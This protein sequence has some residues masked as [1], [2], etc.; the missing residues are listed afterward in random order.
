MQQKKV[1]EYLSHKRELEERLTQA[2]EMAKAA[3]SHRVTQAELEYFQARDNKQFERRMAA[4]RA[5]AEVRS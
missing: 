4:R 2:A 5:A 3:Q 1:E